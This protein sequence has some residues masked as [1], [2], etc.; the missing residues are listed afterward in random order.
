M[1]CEVCH[2]NGGWWLDREGGRLS[3]MQLDRAV[4][5][6]TCSSCISGIAS[7]CDGAVGGP[8]D[9]TNAPHNDD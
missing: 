1:I 8:G 2:G 3:F 4:A 7:C 9:I 6:Q 5:W